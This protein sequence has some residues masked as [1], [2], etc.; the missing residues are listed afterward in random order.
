MDLIRMRES[1]SL[2]LSLHP[3]KAYPADNSVANYYRWHSR[4]N[5]DRET[6]FLEDPLFQGRPHD[7]CCNVHNRYFA[8]AL[9]RMRAPISLNLSIHPGEAYLGRCS[10][11]IAPD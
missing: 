6:D 3:G 11:W 10:D 9:I 1:I 2:N 7:K 4:R 8:M 5:S